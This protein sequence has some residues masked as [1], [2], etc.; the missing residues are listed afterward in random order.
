M[1]C[2]FTVQKNVYNNHIVAYV[3]N[4]AITKQQVESEIALIADQNTLN[5]EIKNKLWTKVLDALTEKE[6]IAKEFERMKGQL[7]ESYVQ[8]KY[9][10]IQKTRFDNDPLKLVEALHRQGKSKTSYKTWIRKEAIVSC[11]YERNVHKPN[12]VSP[13]DIQNY[14][15]THREKFALGRQFDIDQI[16]V[17]KE[18]INT[19]SSIQECL[20]KECSYETHRQNLSQIPGINLNHM[21]AINESEVLPIIAEKVVALP[22]G[23]FSNECIELDGQIIFLG[24]RGIREARTLSLCEVRESIEQTL[25]GERYQKLHQEWL[26]RLKQKAYWVAL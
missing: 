17:K 4:Y 23:S 15:Q 1:P 26:D 11:M 21:E 14:Y 24:L 2:G 22:V 25:L 6:I 5:P 8:K 12:S 16:V 7:P 10:E 19:I 13:L 20:K 9:D 3:E 18:D